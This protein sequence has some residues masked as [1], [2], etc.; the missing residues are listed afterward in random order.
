MRA[1]YAVGAPVRTDARRI[2]IPVRWSAIV[3]PPAALARM[4][5]DTGF[6]LAA[7]PTVVPPDGSEGVDPVEFAEEL[8]ARRLA[9]PEEVGRVARWCEQVR[10]RR[11]DLYLSADPADVLPLWH[12]R[13]WSGDVRWNG[14]R[15]VD[16]PTACRAVCLRGTDGRLRPLALVRM[17]ATPD[18]RRLRVPESP[19]PR[20]VARALQGLIDRSEPPDVESGH[21]VARDAVRVHSTRELP[22]PGEIARVLRQ[23]AEAVEA[24]RSARGPRIGP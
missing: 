12:M 16:E 1:R 23:A 5:R 11:I 4:L 10:P 6:R 21:R 20:W 18:G 3:R 17:F 2:R 8:R 22:D 13:R 24:L 15:L 14:A 19:L 9:R 7:G